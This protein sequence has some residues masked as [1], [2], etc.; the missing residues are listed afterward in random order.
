M[1]AT[2]YDPIVDSSLPSGTPE[3]RTWRPWP[4]RPPF[5]I[6]FIVLCIIL[7]VGI[8]LVIRG[9][10]PDG[11]HVFGQVTTELSNAD[12]FTYNQLPTVLS[13]FLGLLWAV[14][15]HDIM[16]L[17]PYFR[18]SVPGGTSAADSLLLDYPYT[19]APLVPY[20]ATKR[21]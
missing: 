15:H 7:C 9:C 2:P 10:T 4:L 18:M 13:L 16:R 11:C 3:L 6:G 1:T 21:R 19:F 8:D 5:L 20:L 14:P 12:Y 17:E